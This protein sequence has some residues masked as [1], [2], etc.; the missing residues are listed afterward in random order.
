MTPWLTTLLRAGLQLLYPGACLRCG[1]CADSCPTRVHPAGILEA[2][3]F[4]DPEL[5][6]RS[7]LEACIECGICAYVCPSE[8]PLLQG[9]RAMLR[10]V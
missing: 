6:E 8:L 10:K 9:I 3:Q 2:S 5:A 7:G 4:D 1:W